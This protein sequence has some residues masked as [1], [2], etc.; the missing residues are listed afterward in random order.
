MTV[1]GDRPQDVDV[2]SGSPGADG[3]FS[4]VGALNVV[5]QH[6][7][8]IA[9][10]S[11]ASAVVVVAVVLLLP[12]EYTSLS[13]FTPQARRGTQSITSL[14]AQF[15]LSVPGADPAQSPAFYSDLID[16]R[17]I[18]SRVADTRYYDPTIGADSVTLLQVYGNDAATAPLQREAAIKKLRKLITSDVSL[19]TGVVELRVVTRHA[20]LSQQINLRILDLVNEFN[21]RQRQSQ[22]RLERQFIEGRLAE[23][24][25]EL[26]DAEDRL[27][28]F[29]QD[30]RDY[31]NSPNLT[32]AHD[33]LQR[34]VTMRQDIVTSMAQAYEQAK[35]EEIRDSP[36]IT[37]IEEPI[38]P[39]IHDPRGAILKG[40]LSLIA[41]FLVAVGIA[42]GRRA[43]AL[44][45]AG[46]N[47][48]IASFRTLF[49]N[50]IRLRRNSGDLD[51]D[52]HA[53]PPAVPRDMTR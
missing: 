14:A 1:A 23:V 10:C 29:L 32:F 41:G 5:L 33:R 39:V 26:R 28:T 34:D 9:R 27:Q 49:R 15:G 38:V 47:D 51:D 17:E 11:V 48:E 6:W 44:G 19:K 21:L 35:I 43:V 2:R 7:R 50:A 24:R 53:P 31:R 42:F 36:V 52:R 4:V 3:R 22:A 16:S 8:F 25:Q 12:L 30:N 40:I 46:S 20:A 18:M 13:S 45:M 37:V